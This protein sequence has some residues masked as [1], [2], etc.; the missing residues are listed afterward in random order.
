MMLDG[1]EIEM[2]NRE[3]ANVLRAVASIRQDKED[4][5]EV[6]W[7]GSDRYLPGAY[8]LEGY[9]QACGELEQYIKSVFGFVAPVH[10]YEQHPESYDDIER[11]RP[12][13]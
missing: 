2:D 8:E 10:E 4:D 5:L 1:K 11:E 9:I 3:L 13:D 6:N 12:F 7:I